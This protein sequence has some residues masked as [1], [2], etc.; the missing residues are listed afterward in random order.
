MKKKKNFFI[1]LKSADEYLFNFRCV[2]LLYIFIFTQLQ[3]SG[4]K[5]SQK[6][7]IPKKFIALKLERFPLFIVQ[8]SIT[9]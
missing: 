2:A 3:V 9:S 7:N 8:Q 6:N 4:F 5:C 1:F